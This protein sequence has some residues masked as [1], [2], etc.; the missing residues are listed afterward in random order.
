MRL[1]HVI[2]NDRSSGPFTES[3]IRSMLAN[4]TITISDLCWSQGMN[5][6]KPIREMIAVPV[7][8]NPPITQ[9]NQHVLPSAPKVNW[10]PALVLECVATPALILTSLVALEDDDAAQVLSLLSFPILILSVVFSSILH[11]HCWNAIP[12]RFRF[13]SPGKAVGYLF[14]P[15]FNFYWAFVSWPKLNEG[16]VIWQRSEGRQPAADAQGLALIYSILFVCSLTIG[17][18]PGVDILIAVTSLVIYIL[19][20]QQVVSKINEMREQHV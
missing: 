16:L 18:I 15:F 4:R 11:F 2:M 13:T 8:L 10:I 9:S 17:L 6:W 20:Y 7:N 5:E 14:I 12:E 19:F 3:E 1:F